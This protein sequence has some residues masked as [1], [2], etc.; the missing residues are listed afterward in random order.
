MRTPPGI[1]MRPTSPRAWPAVVMAL[2]LC[3]LPDS[4]GAQL[5]AVEAIARN[6]T[7]LSFYYKTGGVAWGSPEL[8]RDAFGL[9]SYGVE[10]LFSVGMVT[11]PRPRPQ[12]A[13]PRPPSD[14]VRVVWTGMTV[15][16]SGD[17]VD[18]VYTYEVRPAPPPPPPP[19]D[20]VWD[21]EMGIGYG[22]LQGFQ[23]VDPTLEFHGA[24]RDLPAVSFYANYQPWGTYL[25]L[26][27]GYMKTRGLQV[28]AEGIDEPFTGDADAFLFGAVIGQAYALDTVDFFVETGY[29]RRAFPSVEWKGPGPLPAGIPRELDMSDWSISAGIQFSLK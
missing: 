3:W 22:Q 24:I 13:A 26:R 4:A 21:L 9:N 5:G 18:T 7:D 2:T 11:R 25:G 29:T 23:M 1:T 17:T 12:V 6:V 16:R 8:K 14:S 10:L 27:T 20:T 19:A 28:T 15:T